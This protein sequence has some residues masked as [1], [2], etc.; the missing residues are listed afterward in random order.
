[1]LYIFGPLHTQIAKWSHDLAH[2][3]ETVNNLEYSNSNSHKHDY[4][5]H[6]SNRQEHDSLAHHHDLIDLFNSLFDNVEDNRPYEN[7]SQPKL[8]IDKHIVILQIKMPYA[9]I[10]ETFPKIIAYN[11]D[12]L[13]EGYVQKWIIP[14]KYDSLG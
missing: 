9:S 5:T 7:D 4:D 1:M 10:V 14:P 13:N 3:G 8:K 11:G 12:S 6:L 2:H